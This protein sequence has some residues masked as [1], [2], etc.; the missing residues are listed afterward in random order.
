MKNWILLSGITCL[1]GCSTSMRLTVP[2]KFQEQA[3]MEHVKGARGNRMSFA[4]FTTTKIK[5]GIHISYPGWGGRGFFLENLL[6]QQTGINKAETVEHEKTKFSYAI[7]DGKHAISVFAREKQVTV[8]LEY[9][10]T[11]PTPGGF[12]NGFEILQHYEYIFSALLKEDTTQDSRNWELMM[13]NLYDRKAAHDKNPFTYISQEDSGLATNGVD[14]IL[15]KPV[16]I[17][18][19]A[20]DNGKSGQLPIKM[21]GGYE[22]SID[23]G[24][25]AIIDLIDRDIWFYNEL[26]ASEKLNI[27]AISTALLARKV[28]DTKW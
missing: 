4:N 24:V 16:S 15:I 7:N 28:H 27:S 18:K 23:G 13:T 14:T 17:K 22:L 9:E 3:T 26:T 10:R 2:D 21:L 11:N 12:L 19:A 6:W 8:K 1:M 25:V 20:L 5:R